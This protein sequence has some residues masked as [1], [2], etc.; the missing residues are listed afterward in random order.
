MLNDWIGNLS[1]LQALSIFIGMLVPIILSCKYLYNAYTKNKIKLRKKLQSYWTNEGII[2]TEESHYI[3][4]NFKTDLDDG[5]I[6]GV[7]RAVNIASKDEMT[8]SLNG[9][10][11]YKTAVMLMTSVIQGQVFKH[12]SVKIKFNGKEIIWKLLKG[13]KQY[14]PHK[15][16][17]VK[18]T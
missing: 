2:E 9:A 5:S 4:I 15:T 11:K 17:L 6:D 10:L 1:P 8:V 7:L 14:F 18:V 16:V 3:Y 13:D 12:G